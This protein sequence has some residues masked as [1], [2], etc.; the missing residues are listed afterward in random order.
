MDS[1]VTD[2]EMQA[3]ADLCTDYFFEEMLPVL[4]DRHKTRGKN[5]LDYLPEEYFGNVMDCARRV[6]TMTAAG[7]E[8]DHPKLKDADVDGAN[9]CLLQGL[10]H[11]HEAEK[12]PAE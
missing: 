11:Q 10:K 3:F 2:V 6:L 4:I 12:L 9:Y 1:V 5:Y 7:A 8:P